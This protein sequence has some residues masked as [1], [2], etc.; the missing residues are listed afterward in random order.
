M[1]VSSQT[2]HTQ[3]LTSQRVKIYTIKM[4][5][6]KSCY[7]TLVYCSCCWKFQKTELETC[8]LSKDPEHA[9]P[10]PCLEDR[11]YI[12]PVCPHCQ[13]QTP[14]EQGLTGADLDEREKL[15]ES[16]YAEAF[17][18]VELLKRERRK[19]CDRE[20]SKK[21]KRD[22]KASQRSSRTED[23][24]VAQQDRKASQKRS[25]TEDRPIKKRGRP[26]THLSY[27]EHRAR[28]R[29]YE[30]NYRDKNHDR[31]KAYNQKWRDEHRDQVR[32][33]TRAWSLKKKLSSKHKEEEAGDAEAAKSPDSGAEPESGAEEESAAEEKAA[34]EENAAEEESGAEEEI[35]VQKERIVEEESSGDE[36]SSSSEESVEE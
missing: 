30:Q 20:Y 8:P 7:Q 22:R 13:S 36:D 23:P 14:E 31:L 35:A 5:H 15:I 21:Y 33:R 25:R 9:P 29:V 10:M 6:C 11:K 28:Q 34:E 19:L 27:E 3:Q 26:P 24:P 16:R 32:A 2:R 17:G 18:R 12:N 1:G 4:N